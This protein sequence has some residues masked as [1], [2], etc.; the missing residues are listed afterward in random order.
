MDYIIRDRDKITLEL[1]ATKQQ[2]EE[3][4]NK[5]LEKD[6]ELNKYKLLVEELRA[7]QS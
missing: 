4:K 6:K 2:L 7:I 5:L 3:C 1:K